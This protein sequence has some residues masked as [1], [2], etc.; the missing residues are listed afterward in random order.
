MLK[1]KNM[2]QFKSEF[3]T[4]LIEIIELL[5]E[6]KIE[7]EGE[8]LEK[9]KAYLSKIQEIG[10]FN[11]E[12]WN[13][14]WRKR[15]WKFGEEFKTYNPNLFLN[16]ID[17]ITLN[18]SSRLEVLEF[19]RSEII[20]N[21]LPDIECKRQ[22][23]SLI[24][25][26]PLNAEFRN[27]LGHYYSR[28]NQIL[29]AI[30]EYKVALKLDTKNIDFLNSRFSKE[31][32]YFDYLI[33]IGEYEKGEIC[34]REL[35]DD[36]DYLSK[37]INIRQTLIDYRRRF[38]D[39]VHF[40]TKLKSLEEDFKIKMHQELDGER[41]RI[42][43]ILG[44][45]SAIVA[46]ILSTVSIGKNFSFIEAVYFII[47]LGIILILFTVALSTLFTTSKTA[48]LKDKKFIILVSSLTLLL[49]YILT[50]NTISSMLKSFGQ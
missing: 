33:S 5:K 8:A 45:F 13:I 19:I 18:S 23:L 21:F 3:L 4:E 31:Q 36:K 15:V 17:N 41:K 22:L 27:T 39:H 7:G 12:N 46:F 32:D 37:G 48:L 10:P 49:I 6:K 35:M 14:S 30:E 26:F 28:E 50:T 34:I 9:F 1:Y 42:I 43:E 29:E 24:E 44:F 47:A 11:V 16:E 25:K 40:Q 20:V 2:T 38:D